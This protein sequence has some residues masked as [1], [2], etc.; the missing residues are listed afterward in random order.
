MMKCTL[1]ED[2]I[3]DGREIVNYTGKPVCQGCARTLGQA[4][5]DRVIQ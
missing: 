5:L 2:D 4:M 3:P 1:C